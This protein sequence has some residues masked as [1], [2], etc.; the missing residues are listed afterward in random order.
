[1]SPMHTI[2]TAVSGHITTIWLNLPR[3][4]NA[5]DSQMAAELSTLLGKLEQDEQVRVVVLRGRGKAFCAGADLHWMNDQGL[6]PDKK[7]SYVLPRLFMSLFGFPKP[8]LAV[9]HGAAMG[10]AMGLIACADFVLATEDAR[11]A[12]SEV[13][14]GLVPATI[15]PFVIRRTGEFRARQ[16]MLTGAELDAELAREAGLVDIALSSDQLEDRLGELCNQL[17]GNAPGAVKT[18]KQLLIHIAGKGL[19]NDLLDHTS[20]VLEKTRQGREA[21]EGIRAFIEKRKPGWKNDLTP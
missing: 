10:G 9:V 1:M 18:S 16:L 3:T 11:F 4:R 6:K 12:F 20:I 19:N 8:L 5:I 7:P 14:L 17:T 15:S 13:R 2:Q 21:E